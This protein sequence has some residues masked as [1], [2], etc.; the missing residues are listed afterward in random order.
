MSSPTIVV[1]DD[2][3]SVRNALGEMLTVFGYAVETYESADSFLQALDQVTA[4]CVVAPTWIK[5]NIKLG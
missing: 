1:I 3:A 4:G 5:L 2:H